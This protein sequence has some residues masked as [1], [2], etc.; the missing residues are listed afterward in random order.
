MTLVGSRQI[1]QE[2]S[3]GYPI[4]RQ[5]M[6]AE[7]EPSLGAEALEEYG[8][9]DRTQCK[10]Q[11]G[12]HVGCC[13]FEDTVVKHHALKWHRSLRRDKSLPVANQPQPERVMVLD[14]SPDGGFQGMDI[15]LLA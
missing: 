1:F 8:A 10:I 7:Q 12:L 14:Q 2:N 6:C 13:F 3:P 11:S 4:N 9:K 5:V 15:W